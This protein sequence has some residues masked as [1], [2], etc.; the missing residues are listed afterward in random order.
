MRVFSNYRAHKP[1]PKPT[2]EFWVVVG[3]D[4]GF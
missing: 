1:L 3:G 2:D 4:D